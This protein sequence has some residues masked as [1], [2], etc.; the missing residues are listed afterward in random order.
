VV[1]LPVGPEV[2]EGTPE[3]VVWVGCDHPGHDRECHQCDLAWTSY[4]DNGLALTIG[5]TVEAKGRGLRVSELD[6]VTLPRVR[7]LLITVAG[8]GITVTYGAM[9]EALALP[10]PPNGLGRLLDLL[11]ED[12]FR[13]GEPSLAAVVVSQSSGEVG[14]AFVGNAEE[15]RKLLDEFWANH[16]ASSR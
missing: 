4:R 12:C 13:R 6:L 3:W 11:S 7:E 1:G 15:E 8:A 16:A 14:S 9:R 10:H 5:E 2:M